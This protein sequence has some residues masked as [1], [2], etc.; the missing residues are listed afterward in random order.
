MNNSCDTKEK[1]HDETFRQRLLSR[2]YSAQFL[3]PLFETVYSR[4]AL[5]ANA[6]RS[7]ISN[8]A[9]P[10][11]PVSDAPLVFKTQYSQLTKSVGIRHCLQF[12]RSALDDVDAEG[13]FTPRSP[14]MCYTRNKNLSDLLCS[15]LFR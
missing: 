14:V 1:E 15:S 8:A 3:Q 11:T 6:A 7:I 10:I 5:L 12:T 13:I 2:G 9:R 4:T